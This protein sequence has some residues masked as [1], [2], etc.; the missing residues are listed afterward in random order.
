MSNEEEVYDHNKEPNAMFLHEVW[1][2]S[3][4]FTKHQNKVHEA[5]K[6]GLPRPPIPDHIRA[7]Y[8]VQRSDLS[9]PMP[10][11]F[12]RLV[13]M[14]DRN[15]NVLRNGLG[16]VQFEKAKPVISEFGVDAGIKALYRNN[17][18]VGALRRKKK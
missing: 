6:H 18:N 10:E 8:I 14:T 3:A 9:T 11:T 7:K 1:K 16:E 5:K 12:E 2:R 4:D 17:M 15:G 13:P